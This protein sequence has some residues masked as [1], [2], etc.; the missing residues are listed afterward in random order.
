MLF[1]SNRPRAEPDERRQPADVVSLTRLF[2]VARFSRHP[3][4][5]D[6]RDAAWEAL[7]SIR[8]SLAERTDDAPGR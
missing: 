5:E 7:V 8:K 4:G 6:E 1:R 3:L 2:E